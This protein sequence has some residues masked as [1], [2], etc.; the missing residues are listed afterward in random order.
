MYQNGDTTLDLKT[1]P[2]FQN[3]Y[4][5]HEFVRN[6][7]GKTIGTFQTLHTH[8]AAVHADFSTPNIFTKN[9]KCIFFQHLNPF[10]RSHS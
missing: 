3:R 7:C 6:F 2:N 8:A 1:P 9:S 5:M 4:Y 10:F